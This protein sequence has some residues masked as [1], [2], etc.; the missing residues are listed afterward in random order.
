VGFEG[1]TDSPWVALVVGA[2]EA[3]LVDA[4]AL[5]AGCVAG[6]ELPPQAASRTTVAKA[7]RTVRLMRG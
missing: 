2:V 6:E 1:L 4:E 5:E 3:E 7:G